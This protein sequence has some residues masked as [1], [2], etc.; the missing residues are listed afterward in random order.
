MLSVGL[1]SQAVKPAPGAVP[2]HERVNLEQPEVAHLEVLHNTPNCDSWSGNGYHTALFIFWNHSR[3]KTAWP[4]DK[5]L[6]L[7][8]QTVLI[9]AYSTTCP[10]QLLPRLCL[11]YPTS[12]S[13]SSLS[14]LYQHLY[15]SVSFC[16][17][18]RARE[19]PAELC[20]VTEA[21]LVESQ[22]P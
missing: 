5:I 22:S 4:A 16:S 11:L 14:E 20:P 19:V 3:K 1:L 18:R 2:P 13:L 7:P 6:R 17:T 8:D 21:E 12:N 10:Q 9:L 15:L